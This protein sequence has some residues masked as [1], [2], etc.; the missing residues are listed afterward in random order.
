MF[1]KEKDDAEFNYKMLNKLIKG[2]ADTLKFA[3]LK[4]YEEVAKTRATKFIDINFNEPDNYGSPKEI[5]YFSYHAGFLAALE[6]ALNIKDASD[7]KIEPIL[8]KL[9]DLGII[10]SWYYN[11]TYHTC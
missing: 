3:M 5:G 1:E 2:S 11:G 4:C 7:K 8:Y 6:A 10:K 9:K